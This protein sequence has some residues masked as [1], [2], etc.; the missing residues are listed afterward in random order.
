MLKTIK[1]NDAPNAIGP[2]SQAVEKGGFIFISGQ[3]PMDPVTQAIEG[4]IEQQTEQVLKNIEAIL[5][6]SELSL[7]N[8]V[9]NTIYVKSMGD[10]AVVNEV[11]SRFFN[12]Y[13][14]ARATIGV[15]EL[16]KGA[17]IEIE[18]IAIR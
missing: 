12:E 11:Y 9:K 18:S 16:P 17:L 1:T 14:P 7:A 8:V 5:K 15:N 13:K 3:L 6:A 2:Y 10:F 4:S